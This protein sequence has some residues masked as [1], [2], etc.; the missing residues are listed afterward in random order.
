MKYMRIWHGRVMTFTPGNIGDVGVCYAPSSLKRLCLCLALLFFAM[1]LF[2][3]ELPKSVQQA[4]SRARIPEDAVSVVVEPVEGNDFLFSHNGDVPMN[5]ASAMKL[6]T[7][8]AA[9]EILGPGNT[10]RTGFWSEVEP[11]EDGV[12]QGD[13]YLKGSGDPVLTQER[14]WRLLRLL[15]E[16]G[17]RT[18]TGNLVLDRSLFRAPQ[19]NP[20]AFDKRPLRAYNVAPDGLLVDFFALRF[21]LRPEEDGV[22]FMMENPNDS[23]TVNANVALGTGGCDGW[24]NRLDVR[25]TRGHLDIAGDFPASCGERFLLLSPLSPDVYIDGLFRSLWRELGGALQGKVRSGNTP[26]DA[27]LLAAQDSPHLSEI[28]RDVNKWSNNVVAR[29]VFLALGGNGAVST[30]AAAKR[31]ADWL[32]QQ[33][34]DFP[35][36]VLENGSG[37]SRIER[38]SADSMNRMLAHAWRAA[39]MPEFLASLPVAAVDG[40]MHQRLKGTAAAGRA[41]IKT[42]YLDGVRTAAGYVQDVNGR[43]Y[44]MTIFINHPNAISGQGAIDALIRQIA[45]GSFAR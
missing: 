27:I 36:L 10:W 37:L 3:S 6:V 4:L 19:G 34:L 35:E 31:V 43:R 16:R 44:A 5:P 20:G 24:R 23:I 18:I 7:A 26:G 25:R 39:T 17:V 38:I 28:V 45:E 33:G 15:R 13:L 41:R 21:I 42:G 2:A 32:A 9:L 8:Y 12:L 22:R 30:E 1:P 29:Q 40:T 11:D 14:F